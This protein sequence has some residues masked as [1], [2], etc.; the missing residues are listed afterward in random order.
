MHIIAERTLERYGEANATAAPS[1]RVW[2]QLVRKARWK[3]PVDVK[4]LFGASVD[5]LKS[6]VVVFD[7]GG[8]KCRISANIKYVN[9]RSRVGRVYIRQVMDHE[10][11]DRLSKT[12]SL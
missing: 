12:G 2:V 8:N 4:R 1:L 7:V 5:F 6:G 9:E 11:Y 3:T 10:L